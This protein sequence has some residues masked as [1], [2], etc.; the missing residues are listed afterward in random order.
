MEKGSLCVRED[1]VVRKKR[2]LVL[3]KSPSLSYIPSTKYIPFPSYHGVACEAAPVTL[4]H[5][6][7]LPINTRLMFLRVHDNVN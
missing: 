5:K 4:A 1:A 7:R 6:L 3:R 2:S